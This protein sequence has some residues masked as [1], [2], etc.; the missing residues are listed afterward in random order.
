M[1]DPLTQKL[2]ITLAVTCRQEWGLVITLLVFLYYRATWWECWVNKTRYKILV[3]YLI[4]I[5][6]FD[7]LSYLFSFKGDCIHFFPLFL[8]GKNQY[9]IPH[10]SKYH[11]GQIKQLSKTHR[12]IQIKTFASDSADQLYPY[13][14]C[15]QPLFVWMVQNQIRP[16][17]KLVCSRSTLVCSRITIAKIKGNTGINGFGYGLFIIHFQ[18]IITF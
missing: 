14:K 6:T 13:M 15:A 9:Y 17:S 4:K 18:E 10:Q 2:H 11:H 7:W 12:M 5:S 1:F 16:N 8:K 3:S